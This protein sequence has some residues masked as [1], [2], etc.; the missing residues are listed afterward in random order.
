MHGNRERKTH[1]TLNVAVTIQTTANKNPRGSSDL[2]SQ[3]TFA[4]LS[5]HGQTLWMKFYKR[6]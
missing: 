1:V 2:R 5:K 6:Y 4:A 3:F